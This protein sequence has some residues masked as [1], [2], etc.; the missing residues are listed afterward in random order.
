M[1]GPSGAP[2]RD[3]GRPRTRAG[4]FGREY[5]LLV[6]CTLVGIGVGA[7][8]LWS[9]KP[10]YVA[11]AR[12]YIERNGVVGTADTA[13]PGGTPTAQTAGLPADLFLGTELVKAAISLGKLDTLTAFAGDPNLPLR[14]MA[15]LHIEPVDVKGE[16]GQIQDLSF[17]DA[18]PESAERVLQS[19]IEAYQAAADR[20]QANRFGAAVAALERQRDL[21]LE[22]LNRK[23]AEA[24]AYRT[25]HPTVV[26]TGNAALSDAR[27]NALVEQRVRAELRRIDADVRLATLQ[28]IARRGQSTTDSH[29]ATDSP[30]TQPASETP[31]RASFVPI[32]PAVIQTVQS[33]GEMLVAPNRGLDVTIQRA[34]NGQMVATTTDPLPDLSAEEEQLEAL[35]QVWGPD[36]PKLQAAKERVEALRRR[37]GRNEMRSIEMVSAYV[38]L[39]HEEERVLDEAIAAHL[40][41]QTPAGDTAIEGQIIDQVIKRAGEMLAKVTDQIEYL[42]LQRDAAQ[43]RVVTL[44]PPHVGVL[45]APSAVPQLLLV[46]TGIGLLIGFALTYLRGAPPQKRERRN[47]WAEQRGFSRMRPRS[48]ILGWVPPLP[49]GA[50]R[51]SQRALGTWVLREPESKAARALR[52]L[53]RRV[54]T[55]ADAQEARTLLVT[56]AMPREGKSVVLA[57]VATAIAQEGRNVLVIDANYDHPSQHVLLSDVLD[58]GNVAGEELTVEAL[59]RGNV[60]VRTQLE[61]LA[62]VP[63]WPKPQR[64]LT[65]L[66]SGAMAE[67]IRHSAARF[68]LILIDGPALS[69]REIVEALAE[70]ADA[71]VF[72]TDG[73]DI[74][75][76]SARELVGGL[77]LASAGVIANAI[78]PRDEIRP[79]P[80]RRKPPARIEP[81][82]ELEPFSP[83]EAAWALDPEP[84][85]G[86]T[87]TQPVTQTPAAEG[88][89]ADNTSEGT[90]SSFG[91]WAVEEPAPDAT[92]DRADDT[93][94]QAAPA[95]PWGEPEVAPDALETAAAEATADS[96]PEMADSAPTDAPDVDATTAASSAGEEIAATAPSGETVDA[97]AATETGNRGDAPSLS[98]VDELIH[99]ELIEGATSG[100]KAPAPEA[101]EAP[102]DAETDAILA[103]AAGAGSADSDAADATAKEPRRSKKSSKS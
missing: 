66:K 10:Q 49:R 88:A 48:T 81:E 25:A 34:P 79:V 61:T 12:V 8:R 27:L 93:N 52:R 3:S 63:A 24:A 73:A 54:A 19:L 76:R 2:G 29:A 32:D 42:S 6:V 4:L 64:P 56:S 31:D 15:G 69:E 82:P 14:I 18:D 62:V 5:A 98:A 26:S 46:P 13:S 1:H 50:G 36:H 94:A 44:V 99:S 28:D 72:L 102:S 74:T 17:Q 21:L 38:Q 90:A 85:I 59:R 65:F 87:I 37:A 77:D 9:V 91:S 86:A 70:V 75:E 22:R 41:A 40:R 57:N 55:T 78:P 35:K 89:R 7:Y 97:T 20:W 95:P 47:A 71:S 80:R 30:T 11:K 100:A 92:A 67:F 43:M 45:A 60:T 83:A 53:A 33:G 39:C 23:Q 16:A 68:D 96:T 58:L 51:G 103:A 101:G 84:T